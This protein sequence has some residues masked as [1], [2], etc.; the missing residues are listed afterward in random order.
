MSQEREYASAADARVISECRVCGRPIG[1]LASSWNRELRTV[2]HW[3]HIQETPTP[4][5]RPV[6][7]PVMLELT[8]P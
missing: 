7:P 8:R 2:L 3:Y 4:D 1:S 6:G 5:H